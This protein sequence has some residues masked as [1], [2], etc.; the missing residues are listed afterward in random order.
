MKK[1]NKKVYQ[2]LV[3]LTIKSP[4]KKGLD[5]MISNIHKWAAG[6]AVLLTGEDA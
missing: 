4:T 2:A 5:E 3:T 6:K 1:K